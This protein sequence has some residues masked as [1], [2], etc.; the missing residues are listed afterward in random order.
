M[1]VINYTQVPFP[2]QI[3]GELNLV[4]KG[5]SPM[6]RL[7]LVYAWFQSEPRSVDPGIPAV[8]DLYLVGRYTDQHRG[9]NLAAD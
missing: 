4:F 3:D 9:T 1:S 8:V 2:P 5:A 7:L 6:S